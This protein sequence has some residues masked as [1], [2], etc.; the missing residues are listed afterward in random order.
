[1]IGFRK[2][3][4]ITSPVRG[5]VVVAAAVI[6]PIVDGLVAA[7]AVALVVLVG[8][9]GET[10]AQFAVVGGVT[11]RVACLELGSHLVPFAAGLELGSIGGCNSLRLRPTARSTRGLGVVVIAVRVVCHALI[12]AY[13][14]RHVEAGQQ[15]LSTPT[16]VWA[17]WSAPY[18]SILPTPV[19]PSA[20]RTGSYLT[21]QGRARGAGRARRARSV[22]ACRV[23][24]AHGTAFVIIIVEADHVIDEVHGAHGQVEARA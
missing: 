9:P 10:A 5:S 24:H 1:M 2:I 8:R 19:T 12:I 4:P 20:G 16:G 11:G 22:V 6:I 13:P 17:S 21:C 15:D 7:L 23:D 18:A 14:G 3:Q